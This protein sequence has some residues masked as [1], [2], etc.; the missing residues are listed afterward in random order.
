MRFVV[1][2]FS[3]VLLAGC[4]GSKPP[5]HSA[6][7]SD[8]TE[9][10]AAPAK[11]DA[12]PDDKTAKSAEKSEADP[13]S[14]PASEAVPTQCAKA[15]ASTCVP[16]RK[17]VERMCA[18]SYPTV[19]LSLF[20]NG[21]PFSRGYLTRRTQ[22]WNAEGGASDNSWLEF[23][24]EVLVLAERGADKG[25]MQVSGAGGSYMALRWNGSCVTLAKEELTL[26]KPPSP[27]AAK[28]EWRYLDDNVQEA[29][30]T[31]STINEA[32]IT[33]RKECK[34]A[35]SGDVSLKCVK[36]DDKLSAVVVDYL[37]KG[38]KIPTPT[39]LPK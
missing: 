21:N 2:A 11:G 15:G 24:E 7:S 36:A 4:G 19:A 10:A 38:G 3:L 22:A 30:R 23:D 34:G 9:P 8:S 35:V 14:A 37:R 1:S 13:G 27:K 17:F 33:R 29:L 5:A 18:D 25:G 12:A 20:G 31:D 26:S 32:V 39:K 28:V 6:D 16:N